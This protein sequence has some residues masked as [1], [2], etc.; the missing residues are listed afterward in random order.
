MDPIDAPAFMT[1]WACMKYPRKG[2]PSIAPRCADLMSPWCQL[3]LSRGAL[4]RNPGLSQPRRSILWFHVGC[5]QIDK[6]LIV[7]LI[8]SYEYPL[9]TPMS[10]WSYLG[11]RI[12]D[13]SLLP[14]RLTRSHS[15]LV[16]GYCSIQVH[17]SRAGCCSTSQ[18]E[19][20]GWQPCRLVSRSPTLAY[21]I[22]SLN[23]LERAA[24]AFLKTLQT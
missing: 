1:S 2:R 6:D 12:N 8:H 4:C 19:I 18:P 3:P 22:S 14:H 23:H 15:S 11:R 13:P 20:T 17:D 7:N 10:L 21:G 16:S 5:G 9:L 24:T